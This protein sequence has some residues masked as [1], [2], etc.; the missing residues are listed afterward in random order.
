MYLEAK[1]LKPGQPGTHLGREIALHTR[2][3]LPYTLRWNFRVTDNRHPRGFSIEAWGDSLVM[4]PIFR[5]NHEW[6]MRRGEESLAREIDRR[7]G[8]PQ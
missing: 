7:R 2:G 3:W 4:K 6:A 5:A 1:E 8:Q